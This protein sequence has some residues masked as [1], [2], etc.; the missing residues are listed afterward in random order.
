MNEKEIHPDF[1]EYLDKTA[2][3]I[4]QFYNFYELCNNSDADT[5]FECIAI[6]SNT[7]FNEIEFNSQT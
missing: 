3:T 7:L 4:N 1:L 2:K 6:A 5:I